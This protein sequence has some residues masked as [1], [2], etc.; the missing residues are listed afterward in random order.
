MTFDIQLFIRWKKSSFSIIRLTL[1]EYSMPPKIIIPVD[2]H[3]II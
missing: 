1:K 2:I 3:E